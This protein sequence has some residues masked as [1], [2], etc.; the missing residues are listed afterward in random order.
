M[1]S[2]ISC[3]PTFG[4]VG[5]LEPGGNSANAP[6]GIAL[7]KF[8]CKQS[9]TLARSTSGRGRL[10]G[11]SW[12]LLPVPTVSLRSA[13]TKAFGIDA[14][15]RLSIS[16]F[17]IA[18]TSALTVRR[19][20]CIAGAVAAGAVVAA[21]GVVEGTVVAGAVVAGAVVAAGVVA[22]AMVVA[23]GVSV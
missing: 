20:C 18:T 1:C 5:V 14:P 21:V 16:A 8:T 12:M 23:G 6:G 9:P 7:V 22:G 11:R 13:K 4:E 3:V 17:G 15:R 19:H 10:P 2:E